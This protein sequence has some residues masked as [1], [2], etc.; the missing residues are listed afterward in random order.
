MYECLF[1]GNIDPFINKIIEFHRKKNILE[2]RDYNE[3]AFQNTVE[4]LLPNEGWVSEMRLITKNKKPNGNFRYKFADIFV[5][6]SSR[7]QQE[8]GL[9][10]NVIIELKVISVLGLHSGR[11]KEVDKKI[12]FDSLKLL[13]NELKTKSDKDLLKMDYCYFCSEK[14]KYQFVT[15]QTI[16]D[17]ALKQI[18]GYI[19][20]LKN[21]K[22][23]DS[24]IKVNMNDG[25]SILGGMG[26]YFVRF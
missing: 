8:I 5:C 3:S 24:K 6:G 9:K 22:V 23:S 19:E 2:F 4:L 11:K 14:G 26:Y 10:S 1:E 16:L 25:I 12:D 13:V 7:E 15:V 20:L 21:G 17:D 18:N